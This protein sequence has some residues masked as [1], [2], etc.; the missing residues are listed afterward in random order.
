[1]K[2]KCIFTKLNRIE[3][4]KITQPE[5]QYRKRVLSSWFKK[6]GKSWLGSK[7]SLGLIYS[8]SFWIQTASYF[9]QSWFQ[10]TGLIYYLA[11]FHVRNRVENLAAVNHVTQT[12]VRVT[13]LQYIGFAG[14][15]NRSLDTDQ[16]FNNLTWF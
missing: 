12:V 5:G 8:L 10:K 11:D 16:S 9:P 15:W 6:F 2:I 14:F 13:L 3:G 1:M 4:R 7:L